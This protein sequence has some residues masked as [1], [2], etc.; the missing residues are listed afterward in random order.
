ML[1]HYD[2]DMKILRE[3]LSPFSAMCSTHGSN[4][5]SN[6]M[7]TKMLMLGIILQSESITYQCFIA[8]YLA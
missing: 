4:F 1:F 7:L 5:G 3:S 2:Y 8:N 6:I